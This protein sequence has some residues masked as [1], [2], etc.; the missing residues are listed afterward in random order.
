MSQSLTVAKGL[1]VAKKLAGHVAELQGRLRGA[2]SWRES[3]PPAFD[4]AATLVAH[5]AAVD[6]LV[7]LRSR[8]AR[9]NAF[10]TLSHRGCE[11]TVAE[12]IRRADELKGRAVLLASLDLSA[13]ERREATDYDDRGRPVYETVRQ[14]AVWTPAERAARVEAIR[15]ELEELVDAIE[16]VNHQ[17]RLT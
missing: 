5:D 7:T 6:E 1:R 11:L 13:G 9:A 10:T 17:T 3:Q 4:F 8:I 2:S 12:A 14:V 16:E 15:A